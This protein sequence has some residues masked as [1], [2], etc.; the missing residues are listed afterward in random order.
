MGGSSSHEKTPHT[1]WGFEV[2]STILFGTFG[3]NNHSWLAFI[4]KYINCL[5]QPARAA[6]PEE[7]HLHRWS[8][9]IPAMN[10]TPPTL[11]P[12][13]NDQTRL[14]RAAIAPAA[15]VGCVGRRGVLIRGV[16]EKWWPIELT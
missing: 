5:L 6:T 1:Y 9:P 10:D 3:A 14:T 2:L 11:V 15:R 12:H 4:S 16:R 8:L 7:M 13:H